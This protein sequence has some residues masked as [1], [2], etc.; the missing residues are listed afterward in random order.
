MAIIETKTNLNKYSLFA[1]IIVG[2]YSYHGT[3]GR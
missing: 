3:I 2:P 1:E